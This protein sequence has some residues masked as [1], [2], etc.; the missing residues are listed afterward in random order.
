MSIEQSLSQA[1]MGLEGIELDD[2][3]AI[4]IQIE[5]PEGVMIGIDGMEIDLMPEEEGEFDE[6]L[7][8]VMDKGDL[9]KMAS[10]L[11][12]MVDADIN[13]RKDVQSMKECFT[14]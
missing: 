6:N 8:D 1:P 9:Q 7:A 5:N 12:E 2:T 4:E 14:H 11:I 3:P 10:D 13:S